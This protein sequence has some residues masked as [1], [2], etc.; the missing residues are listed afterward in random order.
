MGCP[1]PAVGRVEVVEVPEGMVAGVGLERGAGECPAK[2]I[3]P[4]E[5]VGFGDSFLSSRHHDDVVRLQNNIFLWSLA[6]DDVL[7][8]KRI[9]YLP[10]VY[11]SQNVN[12]FYSRERSKPPCT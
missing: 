10:S 12:V 4:E 11:D 3:G 7:I 6:L 9:F 2:R 1:G 5:K 8:M